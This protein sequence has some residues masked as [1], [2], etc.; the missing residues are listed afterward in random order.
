M[1]YRQT[2]ILPVILALAACATPV[3]P[4]SAAPAAADS[5]SLPAIDFP[6][7]PSKIVLVNPFAGAA[8]D[9]EPLPLSTGDLW[10]RIVSGYAIPD[11]HG[12]A[13]EKWEQWYVARPDYVARMVERSRRYLYHIVTEVEARGMPTE[14]A[15]LPIVESAFNP[16]ALSVS[17]ASGIWQFMPQTGKTYG[18]KQ[19]WWFDSRRDVIA[20]TSSALDYLQKL[21]AEFNDWQLSLAAYNWGEGNVRR[22][23]ARNRAKGLPVDFDSLTNVADETRNYVPKLQ[24]VKNIIADP[25]KY[26]LV[27][28]AV[29][30]APYFTVVN[31]TV[32]MD[33]KR[34]AELAEL[35]VDE[36]LALNPQHNR[37]VIS[38]ADEY[39]ILLPIDKAEIFAAKLNLIDQPLVSWQA[40]RMKSGETLPQIAIRYGMSIE[41]LRSVNGIGPRE[42]VP[43]GYALLVPMQRPTVEAAESLQDAVFTTVPAGRTFY[44]A[45]RRGDTLTAIAGRYGV[46]TQDLRRWNHLAHNSV[47]SGQKLRVTSDVAPVRSIRARAS[48]RHRL[49]AAERGVAKGR[50]HGVVAVRGPS[51]GGGRGSRRGA[52]IVTSAAQAER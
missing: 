49:R 1:H 20:A 22:A 6:A 37:P 35:P 39:A 33:V 30:N 12:P 24:A 47:R 17:R 38:G 32:R 19:N 40:H 42:T 28:A 14:I 21:N 26:G 45:V 36:F 41:T 8:A 48:D 50:H 2:L 25:Q 34:A 13:V 29:P 52:S 16:N 9:L 4:P 51:G 15:L 27:L 3:P 18:L 43:T 44:Y 46:T 5:A 23:V 7:P 11:A 31:T 10:D